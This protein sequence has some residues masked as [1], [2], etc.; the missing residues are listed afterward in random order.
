MGLKLRVG[1]K[2]TQD[3]DVKLADLNLAKPPQK[4]KIMIVG[5]PEDEINKEN[6]KAA[7]ASIQQ[8]KEAEEAQE[9]A[10]AARVA[11]AMKEAAATPPSSSQQKK[12]E[13]PSPEKQI[14]AIK[15]Q[16]RAIEEQLE[17]SFNL[18]F[19]ERNVYFECPFHDHH[20]HGHHHHGLMEHP[21][22][23]HVVEESPEAKAA[24]R[25]KLLE[26]DEQLT[27][28]TLKLDAVQYRASPEEQ[29]E[30]QRTLSTNNHVGR[31]EIVRQKRKGQIVRI[32][33]IQAAIDQ[34]LKTTYPSDDSGTH[35]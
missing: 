4:T 33:K 6:E 26:T 17:S 10:R 34:L 7:E 27:R 24:K 15:L 31:E 32:Q 8:R 22:T 21:C 9:A 20:D 14:K 3:D 23:H 29:A 2:A 28:L 5:S 13:G 19:Q 18:K 25:K 35:M 30:Q 12:E 1:S 16:V 11:A